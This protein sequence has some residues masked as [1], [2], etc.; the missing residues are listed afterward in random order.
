MNVNIKLRR[1]AVGVVAAASALSLTV[2]AHAATGWRITGT[3]DKNSGLRDIAVVDAKNAWAVGYQ[4]VNGQAVPVVR[5]WNGKTWT[6]MALPASTKGAYLEHVSASSSTNV[7]VSGSNGQRKQYWMRWNGKSWAVVTADLAKN[8][9]PHAPRLLAVGPGDV[10]SFGVTG[11]GPATP[12][13]RHYNGRNWS[14]V[15]APGLISKWSA[16]SSKDIWATGWIDAGTGGPIPTVMRWDGK[17]WKK[18]SQPLGTGYEGTVAGGV[19]AFST[20]NVWV[21]GMDAAGRGLLL[22]WNGKTWKKYVAPVK[23][24]L[25]DLVYD[26][27]G[28]L[29]MRAGQKFLRLNSGKW[30]TTSVP[31]RTGL[32][33]EVS[34]LARV[35][36]TTS[37][38]GVGS[39]TDKDLIDTSSVVLK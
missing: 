11:F 10:W 24:V 14:K 6:R 32:R 1:S 36:K 13:L 22:R 4:S 15:K 16:L 31:G 18:H 17:S 12:D 27:D 9:D 34:A 21:S 38:W 8:T 20:T 39:L 5:R 30:T 35:P 26:G 37:V 19:L 33:T 7:W 29:W 28:G 3:P 25:S 23:D 2:P